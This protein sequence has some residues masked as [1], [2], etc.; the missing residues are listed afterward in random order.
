V[1]LNPG[2]INTDMLQQ[3]WPDGAS[4]HESAAEWAKRAVPMLLK[5]GPADNGKP[6][7]VR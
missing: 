6:L 3:C 4:S 7:T 2:I 5:I 1:A